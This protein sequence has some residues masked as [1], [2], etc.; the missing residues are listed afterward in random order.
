MYKLTEELLLDSGVFYLTESSLGYKESES[1]IPITRW[2]I[3]GLA[4]TLQ[5]VFPLTS[6]FHCTLWPT[7]SKNN[8]NIERIHSLFLAVFEML[9]AITVSNML[10][11]K[12]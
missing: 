3:L 12:F 5:M 2:F 9:L 1:S 4:F 6:D 8:P 7:I 11:F 10:G